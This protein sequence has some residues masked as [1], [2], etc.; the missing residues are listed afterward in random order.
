MANR[1]AQRGQF[2][3]AII[4]TLL[5]VIVGYVLILLLT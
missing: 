2:V 1:R 4:G 5:G 3:A